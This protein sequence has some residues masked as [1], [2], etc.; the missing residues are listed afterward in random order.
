MAEIN[1]GNDTDLNV[2]LGEQTNISSTVYDINYI[3]DYIK[4][5]QE[6]RA[7]E[8]IRIAN[9]E[10]RQDNEEDRIALYEELELK[11]EQDYWR[12]NGIV[13]TEKTSTSGLIDTYT[14]T[15]DDGETDT[16]T[17]SNG[18]GG[19]ITS[20]TA[21]VDSN[22]GTPS[23]TVTTGGTEHERTIALAFSNMKGEKGN[24]GDPGQ[25]R[26]LIVAELPT[27]DIDTN[28]IY[29]VPITPDTE[30]NNYEEYI[31]VNNEWELLG[32]IGVHVDLTNYVTNTD[33][34]TYATAGVVK[35]SING[36]QVDS[37]GNPKAYNGSYANYTAASNDLFIGKGT[38]ESVIT[39]K[40]LTTKSY[41]DGLVGD[42]AS[43]LDEIQGEI[44]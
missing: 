9:E 11:K 28:A 29:L 10:T 18:E 35:S 21:S 2:S 36:F 41:V 3:P 37:S 20:V 19:K 31:Y 7:N 24:T 12:G 6:R 34:S 22:V 33:Y 40:G 15:Y 43:A 23:V 5:E 27:E 14:I 39:G 32:K 1:L 4:A 16:F 13:S 25:I 38:L 17:V 30:D 8:T 44:I 26:F 42:I